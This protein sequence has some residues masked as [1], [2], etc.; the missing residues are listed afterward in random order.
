MISAQEAWNR[1]VESR[2][3][4]DALKVMEPKIEKAILEAI[5]RGE[6]SITYTFLPLEFETIATDLTRR[7]VGAGYRYEDNGKNTVTFT[8]KPR[9]L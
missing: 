1:T 5:D 6:E 4:L 9:G 8:W 7:M 2:K 3:Q